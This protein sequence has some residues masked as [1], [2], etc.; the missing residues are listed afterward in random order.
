MGLDRGSGGAKVMMI[1]LLMMMITIIV[2]V[3]LE[4]LVVCVCGVVCAFGG[5]GK[6]ETKKERKE[7]KRDLEKMERSFVSVNSLENNFTSHM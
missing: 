7:G 1:T 4:V 6:N 3:L 2:A 5:D